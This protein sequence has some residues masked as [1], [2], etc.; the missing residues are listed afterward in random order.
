MMRL[1]SLLFVLTLS[2]LLASPAIAT[3]YSWQ[4]DLDSSQIPNGISTSNGLGQAWLAYQTETD[5]LQV[6]VAW[7]ALDGNLTGIHIHG[8]ALPGESTRTHIVDVFGSA[9]DIPSDLDLRTDLHQASYHL[10]DA[11]GG[12]DVPSGDGHLP[13]DQAL[14]AM[15]AGEAYMVFHSEAW[16][17]GELRGQLPVATL[18]PEPSTGWLAL[19]GLSLGALASPS[20]RRS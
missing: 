14:A 5:H 10:G 16:L 19:L 15:V 18:L 12:D 2:L 6:L 20:S 17:D 8:P 7:T 9:T 11:H 1:P 4:L 13:L 3:R